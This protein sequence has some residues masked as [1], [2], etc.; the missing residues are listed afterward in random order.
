MIKANKGEWSEFYVMLKLLSDQGFYGVNEDLNPIEDLYY[1]VA[2]VYS[3]DKDLLYTLLDKDHLQIEKGKR[4]EKISTDTI[5][6][7][8][9]PI[10]KTIKEQENTTFSISE[11]DQIMKIL[12]CH[13]IKSG[14]N[15]KSDIKI[16][17][18]DPKIEKFIT[19][20]FSIKSFLAGK[21]TLLN[22]SAHTLFSYEV[23]N[24]SKNDV[25]EINEIV[26]YRDSID[27]TKRIHEIYKRRG[28]I[29][30][31]KI[32]SESMYKNLKKIDSLFPILIAN[33][34]LASYKI[35]EKHLDI[36]MKKE[37][38]LIED[39]ER[40]VGEFLEAV[41]KGM[42]PS[43]EWDLMNVANGLLLVVENGDI[44]GFHVY[45]RAELI[46][47]LLKNSYFDTPSTSR[48]KFGY[49]YQENG[50]ILLDLSLQI[51]LK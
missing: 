31:Y 2:K 30:F 24:L 33:L 15:Q 6:R 38:N 8:I 5:S 39:E 20:Y 34:L 22:A 12:G 11:A 17:F 19:D 21:P 25:K 18:K 45:N 50:K 26:N 10:L 44:V 4:T 48:H 37:P 49:L 43:I 27:L 47:F 42:I 35:K 41:L 29:T 3:D 23:T 46:K 36:L 51:R 14:A 28:E 40:K 7:A 16:V 13:S 1:S 32:K 9:K